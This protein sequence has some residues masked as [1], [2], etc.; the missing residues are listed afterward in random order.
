MI[1]RRIIFNITFKVVNI[2]VY[3]SVKF[4]LVRDWLNWHKGVENIRL[5]FYRVEKN[6]RPKV[7]DYGYR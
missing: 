6:M 4:F 1:R 2:F 5:Y 7:S 3:H